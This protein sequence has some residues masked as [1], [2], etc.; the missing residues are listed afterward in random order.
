LQRVIIAAAL[1]QQP[2]LLLL[3]EPATGIDVGVRVQFYELIERLRAE[4]SMG[5]L[6]VSHDLSVVSRYAT[7]VGVY[8]PPPDLHGRARRGAADARA[9]GTLRASR[10]GCIPIGTTTGFSPPNLQH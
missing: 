9:G 8:P 4:Q 2:K 5:I 1:A 7:R 6:I 10:G 3:D